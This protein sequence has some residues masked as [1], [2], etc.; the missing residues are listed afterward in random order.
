MF[1]MQTDEED[2]GMVDGSNMNVLGSESPTVMDI[3]NSTNPCIFNNEVNDVVCTRQQEKRI[4]HWMRSYSEQYNASGGT[5]AVLPPFNTN[6]AVANP[7]IKAAL[8]LFKVQQNI[9]LLD[10]QRVEVRSVYDSV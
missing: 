7:D 5:N 2:S 1:D 3:D 9:Y 8:S 10:F 6:A 4:L